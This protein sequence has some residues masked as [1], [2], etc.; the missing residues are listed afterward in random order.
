MRFGLRQVFFLIVVI[1]CLWVI[2][3]YLQEVFWGTG[4]EEINF[5][6]PVRYPHVATYANKRQMTLASDHSANFDVFWDF[7]PS[8]KPHLLEILDQYVDDETIFVDVGAWEGPVLFY[9]ASKARITLGIEPDPNAFRALSAHLS[10]NPELG[11][12]VS[13]SQLCISDRIE[14]IRMAGWGEGST[15]SEFVPIRFED[16]VNRF[17]EEAIFRV[18]CEPL[19]KFLSDRGIRPNNKMFV[20]LDIE[21]SEAYILPDLIKW[22]ESLSVKPVFYVGIHDTIT[23]ATEN[24]RQKTL[25]F[26]HLF[27]WCGRN[28]QE[29]V[30]CSK[31]TLTDLDEAGD[32]LLTFNK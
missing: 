9:A 23:I 20:K 13:I 3:Q 17:G 5:H 19:Y 21:G 10:M 8:W 24:Q 16:E 27:K 1:F 7:L 22:V 14:R 15:V 2:A 30:E 26:F 25:K 31:I 29:L 11:S 12:R 6:R 18:S 28:L 32:F 4:I